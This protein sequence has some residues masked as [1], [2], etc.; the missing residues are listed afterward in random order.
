M[1]RAAGVPEDSLISEW[2]SWVL[3]RGR[4][5]RVSAGVGDFASAL[6][7]I[8]LLVAMATR[9]GRWR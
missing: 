2:R 9:S 5:E 1:A 3:S 4:S 6:I 7:F 8:L